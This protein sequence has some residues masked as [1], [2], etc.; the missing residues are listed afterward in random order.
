MFVSVERCLGVTRSVWQSDGNECWLSSEGCSRRLNV[1]KANMRMK[2]KWDMRFLNFDRFSKIE[3]LNIFCDEW[4]ENIF[5]KNSLI[6]KCK[7]YWV[8]YVI[9]K[10]WFVFIP[11]F[12]IRMTN[13]ARPSTISIPRLFPNLRKI[14][15]SHKVCEHNTKSGISRSNEN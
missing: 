15:N 11:S 7:E 13:W 2:W 5:Q 14:F 1:D 10:F 6:S 8:V 3:S 9:L 12:Q 4:S